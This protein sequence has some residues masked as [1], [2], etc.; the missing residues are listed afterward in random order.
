MS[1]QIVH[2]TWWDELHPLGFSNKTITNFVCFFLFF[3]GMVHNLGATSC[4]CVLIK[5]PVTLKI[6][7]Y[8]AHTR[9]RAK[10]HHKTQCDHHS[11]ILW[12][13]SLLPSPNYK[14]FHYLL[15]ARYYQTGNQWIYSGAKWIWPSFCSFQT[16]FNLLKIVCCYLYDFLG[17]C[18]SIGFR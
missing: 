14:R 1:E 3:F 16:L 12:K 5:E 18:F 7:A 17:K 4:V 13:I 10:A 9:E 8:F 6:H 15:F 11:I 2:K